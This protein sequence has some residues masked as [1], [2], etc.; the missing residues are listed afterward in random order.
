MWNN[1]IYTVVQLE[2]PSLSFKE[3]GLFREYVDNLLQQ[4]EHNIIIDLSA[5]HELGSVGIGTLFSISK[6]VKAK[7][8]KLKLIGVNSMV[9]RSLQMAKI[10]DLIETHLKDVKSH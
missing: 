1:T 8:G 4:G 6:K 2:Q 9:Y 10:P 3:V 5:L 7:E